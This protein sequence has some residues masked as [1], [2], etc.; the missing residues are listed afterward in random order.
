MKGRVALILSVLGLSLSG[1]GLCLTLLGCFG[2]VQGD[3]GGVVV[4]EPDLYLFGGYADGGRGRDYGRRGAQS[5]G[6]GGG[7]RR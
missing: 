3:G 6:R 5:R 1:M 2:Y 4:A 7:G